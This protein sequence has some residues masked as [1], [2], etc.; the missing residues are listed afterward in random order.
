MEIDRI[1]LRVPCLAGRVTDCRKLYYPGSRVNQ[2]LSIDHADE[3]ARRASASVVN[4]P[5]S[6][7]YQGP[8]Q[9]LAGDNV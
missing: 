7:P 8:Y 3:T 6:G 5:E 1:A 2:T 9:G 4:R